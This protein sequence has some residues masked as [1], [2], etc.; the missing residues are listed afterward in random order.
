MGIS[1]FESV[2]VFCAVLAAVLLIA[3]ALPA[4]AEDASRVRAVYVETGPV[5][6]GVLDDAVWQQAEVIDD[7]VQVLPVPGAKP[8][9]RTE[10]RLLRDAENLYIAYRAYEDSPEQIVAHRLERDE[11]FFDD[12]H[13]SMSIDPFRDR[14]N[15][16]FFMVNPYGGRRE[17]SFEGDLF[18]TEWDGIWYVETQ[19]DEQGWTVELA[20]PFRSI[21]FDP[22]RDDWGINFG[23]AMARSGEELRWQNPRPDQFMND[24]VEAGILEGMRGAH[25]GIGLDMLP[26]LSL[27]RV[28]QPRFNRPD[29]EP[30]VVQDSRHYTRLEPSL[31]AFYKL[32]PSMTAALTVNTDFGETE[33]DVAQVN[34]TQYAIFYPEKRDFF[35][36]DSG[37]FEFAELNQSSLS[38]SSADPAVRANGLPFY[39]RR[40]GIQANGSEVGLLAGA[41]LTGRVGRF[42]VGFLDVETDA[43][44][45]VGRRNLGVMRI[46]ANV[47][48]E[49]TVGLIATR[50]NPDGND[51]DA[52]VGADFMYRNGNFLPGRAL[53]GT[54]WLQRSLNEAGGRDQW[55]YGGRIEYP[56][57]RI[58]WSLGMRELQEDFDPKL[59]FVNRVGI[60][61]YE[62]GFRYRTRTDGT[63]RTFDSEVDALLVTDLSNRI[64]SLT[65]EVTPLG[66]GTARRGVASARYI[67]RFERVEE[68]FE[69]SPGVVIPIGSYHFQQGLLA[70]GGSPMR[71]FRP[72]FVLKG[73]RFYGGTLWS[74]QAGMEWRPTYRIFVKATYSENHVDLPQGDFV[75]RLLAMRLDLHPSANLS[76]TNLIQYDNVSKLAGINSRL[77]WI[78]VEGREIFLVWN[79]GFDARDGQLGN[80][81]TEA[82]AKVGWLMRF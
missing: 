62:A 75:T 12:D 30:S 17:V 23:R 55:A 16:Y 73:G 4:L 54:F 26:S 15:G 36:Q 52:L 9:Q 81:R 29:W 11:F 79:Q 28:D 67:Q 34:L 2:W 5:I 80:R 14:L 6:D 49:S 71:K 31:D 72:G 46:A 41:K 51:S 37:I 7:L 39:S 32:T 74:A 76:W 65:A 60:R 27:K 25:Q 77:R 68:P 82:I 21:S 13:V 56:N 38:F 78:P 45:E 70:V 58:K 43:T 22:E 40:I 20:L 18:E 35:L 3:A 19:I 24:M 42:K 61:Q 33:V 44:N 63:I 69:I 50:G 64:Q 53:T 57:D 48:E 10:V 47:L 8:S 59:G 1:R 66:L